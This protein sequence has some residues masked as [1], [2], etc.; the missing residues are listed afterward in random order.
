M[1]IKNILWA[2]VGLALI[3]LNLSAGEPEGEAQ[4]LKRRRFQLVHARHADIE[5][6]GDF[7]EV[8]FLQILS[9][10]QRIDLGLL[11]AFCDQL[12]EK[13]GGS[14]YSSGSN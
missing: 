9:K 7:G 1:K 8:Q 4:F 2:G 5:D 6:G 14:I 10:Q 12:Q 3:S 13:K 11:R